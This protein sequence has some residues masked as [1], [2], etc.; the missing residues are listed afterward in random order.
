LGQKI[1]AFVSQGAQ[2]FVF[3]EAPLLKMIRQG[4]WVLL[5]SVDS[6]PHEVEQLMSLLEENPTLSVYDGVHPLHFYGGI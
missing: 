3:K 5:D 2:N 1:N 6:A 4:G